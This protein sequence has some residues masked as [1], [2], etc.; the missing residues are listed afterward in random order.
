M[1]GQCN[2]RMILGAAGVWPLMS[3]FSSLGVQ[4]DRVTLKSHTGRD[5]HY[6]LLVPA[7]GHGAV[8]IILFSHGAQSAA[9]QY[10]ALLRPLCQAGFL[11][12]A[13]D[14]PDSG[15]PPAS[16][17]PEGLWRARVDDL[18]APILRQDEL[19]AALSP[20]GLTPDFT[21]V[22][23]AGHSF[24]GAVAQAVAG[25]TMHFEP[26]A[27]A[28]AMRFDGVSGLIALSP[29]GPRAGL[30]PAEAWAS[31]TVPS[32]LV[33]GTADTLPGFIDRW[34]THAGGF[35]INSPGNRWQIVGDGVDHF[36]GGLI[37]KPEG[38][39][40]DQAQAPALAAVA[41]TLI[42]FLNQWAAGHDRPVPPVELP[43]EL[44][45]TH[46]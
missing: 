15:G 16:V 33:T 6:R 35:E 19:K 4:Q 28:R 36:F 22:C 8:P 11:V 9:G 42:H 37:G 43:T 40:V 2:R 3:G 18:A 1:A 5:V 24:G 17:P 41:H 34:E 7:Q 30:V 45:L 26:D 14:H 20:Y 39:A 12:I 25:A 32:V 21:R 10:D 13:P 46:L 23:A 29:P 27:P 38:I 31:V 44:V